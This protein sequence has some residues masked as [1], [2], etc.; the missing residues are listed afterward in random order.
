MWL[1]VRESFKTPGGS[2]RGPTHPDSGGPP[3]GSGD[4]PKNSKV[5]RNFKPKKPKINEKWPKNFPGAFGAGPDPG[6]FRT[7]PLGALNFFLLRNFFV[8]NQSKKVQLYEKVKIRVTFLRP[9]M[10]SM[11]AQG[12]RE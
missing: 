1:G 2:G 3:G 8:K 12:A 6:F 11:L 7:P 9:L 10:A 4:P 5:P